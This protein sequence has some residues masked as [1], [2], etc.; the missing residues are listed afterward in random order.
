M[1]AKYFGG[2]FIADISEI[3]SMLESK[4]NKS[5]VN[6]R[7]CCIIFA[8]AENEV[9]KSKIIPMVDYWNYRS[10]EHVDFFFP[11]YI[12]DKNL[13]N[14]KY[15]SNTI[16][17]EPYDNV[18]KELLIELAKKSPEIWGDISP[19]KN[20]NFDSK[21][22]VDT[23]DFFKKNSKWEYSGNPTML[24]CRGFIDN[25]GDAKLDLKTF[26]QIDLFKIEKEEA[27]NTIDSLFESIIRTSEKKDFSEINFDFV[28]EIYGK[29]I[30]K[31]LIRTI[32]EN[33][34]IKTSLLY[35]SASIIKIIKSHE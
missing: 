4:L 22:F 23:L 12:G 34:P 9:S 19:E 33:L 28:K 24:L 21:V 10:K 17:E 25:K 29:S 16:K 5:G 2:Y 15:T 14:S 35:N 3:Y 8:H 30:V 13:G 32:F 18:T 26:L 6:S 27:T 7:L 20:K 11:G 31:S 1:E